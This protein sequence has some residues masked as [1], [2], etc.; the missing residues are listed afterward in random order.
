MKTTFVKYAAIITVIAILTSCSG[1]DIE[2]DLAVM[3]DIQGTWVGE[4]LAGNFY[5]HIKVNITDNKFDGWLQISDSITE[6]D[7][8]IL[9]TERGTFSI[10][11]V[12]EKVSGVGRY[13]SFNFAILGRCC[14]D[15]SLTAKTLSEMITYDNRKGLLVA[16][17][18]SMTR[19][20]SP[21]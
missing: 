9:P 12:Q 21:K 17:R 11:S 18:V 4:D 19:V 16:G 5:R 13:R 10:S 3:K 2:D 14:G 7:W 6:P 1:V 15:N 20:P 8:S